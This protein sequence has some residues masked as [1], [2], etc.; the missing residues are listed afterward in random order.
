MIEATYKKN[1]ILTG[2][3]MSST[4]SLTLFTVKLLGSYELLT[5]F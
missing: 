4:V 5:Y 1:D 3:K 2:S